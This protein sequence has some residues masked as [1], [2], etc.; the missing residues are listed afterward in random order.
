MKPTRINALMVEDVVTAVH[1]T[2]FKEVVR[3]LGEHRVSGLP[4]IDDDRKVI[5]VISETDLML[6]QTRPPEA[7]GSFATMARRLNR[8]VRE[9]AAKSRARTAGGVMST[10]AV[11]VRADAT[12][13]EAAR[14]MAEHRI[15]RLPVVDEDHR[16]VGIVTRHDLLQVFLRGDEDIQRDVQ[17]E[18]FVNTL[19]IAPHTVE[20]TV[21]NGVVTL[22]GQLERRS[23]TAVAVGMTR[24]L[25]GVVDVVDHLSYRLDDKR[26]RPAEQALHG[27][28]D[29]WLRGL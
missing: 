10:P 6:H 18:V 23:D 4:V 2:P 3:L 19:W 1:G 8:A 11:T 16:L 7:H 20:A 24:R 9:R 25:D 22:T 13:T 17:R 12:V 15:E 5:G 28:A 29:D 27:V 21:E 26:L 14:L